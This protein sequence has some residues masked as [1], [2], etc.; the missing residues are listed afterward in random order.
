MWKILLA[1]CFG[2]VGAAEDVVGGD[3]VVAAKGQQM[4]DGQ[5]VGAALVAGVHG[6]GGAEDFGDLLLGFIVVFTE[7]AEAFGVVHKNSYE[8]LVIINYIKYLL[9]LL[10]L[11]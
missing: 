9:F 4:A 6:L 2:V 7:V 1:I 5:L 3:A 8:N 11:V 10:T